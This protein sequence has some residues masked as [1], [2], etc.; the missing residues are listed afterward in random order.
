MECKRAIE[1]INAFVKN[2]IF[3]EFSLYSYSK[4]KLV[5]VGSQNLSY[6]HSIEIHLENP[7]HI[8]SRADW[9]VNVDSL[10]V[11]ELAEL[12]F[13]EYNRKNKIE[14]GTKALKFIDQDECVF[15]YAFSEIEVFEKVVKYYP[16]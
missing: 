13:F 1:R 16:E 12:E 7:F 6:Y 2:F 3:F 11:K 14:V 8:D 15:Y 5:I 4:E 9:I 10:V